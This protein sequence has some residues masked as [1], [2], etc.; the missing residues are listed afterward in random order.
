MLNDNFGVLGYVIVGV[1]VVSWLVSI[2]VYRYKRYD[3]IEVA[4]A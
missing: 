3:E 4:S 1:F 2:A